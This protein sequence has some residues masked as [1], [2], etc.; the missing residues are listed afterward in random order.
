LGEA[1]KYP[2]AA[3]DRPG[4]RPRGEHGPSPGCGAFARD[5]SIVKG[6]VGRRRYRQRGLLEFHKKLGNAGAPV[7][8]NHGAGM[9]WGKQPYHPLDVRVRSTNTRLT[10]ATRSGRG[11]REYHNRTD[12]MGWS[13]ASF[14]AE[15]FGH[16]WFEGPGSC[17]RPLT[18]E[19]R[20]RR[21][22]VHPTEFLEGTPQTRAPR[23]RRARGRRR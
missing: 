20:S 5:P 12:G 23:S 15:L 8:E 22:S 19:R 10:S 21:G 2:N 11:L 16:W 4:T 7:L 3:G 1:V 14:D 17:G 9:T 18:P 6:F 13:F